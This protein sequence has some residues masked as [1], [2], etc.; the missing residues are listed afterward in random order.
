[1]LEAAE[2]GL[3]RDPRE[4]TDANS[5]KQSCKDAAHSGIGGQASPYDEFKEVVW[6]A[7]MSPQALT[8]NTAVVPC[9][10]PGK[11]TI[12]QNHAH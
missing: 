5:D 1:M 7:S 2:S 4:G 12:R 10:E 8:A 6:V 11:L 3:W 9:F